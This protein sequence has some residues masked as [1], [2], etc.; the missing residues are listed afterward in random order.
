M[1]DQLLRSLRFKCKGLPKLRCNAFKIQ[2][3]LFDEGTV[4]GFDHLFDPLTFEDNEK[5]VLSRKD[6]NVSDSSDEELLSLSICGEDD[7]KVADD[8][9]LKAYIKSFEN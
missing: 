3:Y 1:I 2:L 4:E 9:K 8:K 5:E 6:T 7:N